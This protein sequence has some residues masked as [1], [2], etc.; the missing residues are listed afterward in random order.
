MR[1]WLAAP[2]WARPSNMPNV[3]RATHVLSTARPADGGVRP[4]QG[5]RGPSYGA[6]H[7]QP[8][9]AHL[10]PLPAHCVCPICCASLSQ[11]GCPIHGTVDGHRK[12][13]RRP[14]NA[15][16]NSKISLTKIFDGV[17]CRQSHKD[18]GGA[19]TG[20]EQEMCVQKPRELT[21]YARLCPR[22]ESNGPRFWQSPAVIG[23]L[24]SIFGL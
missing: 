5:R 9:A 16:E 3:R 8:R 6:Q 23:V 14:P 4:A 1:L 7:P 2:V 21:V 15:D 12:H 19:R 24:T 20:A 13:S 10:G 18:L 11:D 22:T 17:L